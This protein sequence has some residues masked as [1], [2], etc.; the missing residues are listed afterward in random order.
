[1]CHPHLKPHRKDC[2]KPSKYNG[3]RIIL[4]G[5]HMK[6]FDWKIEKTYGKQEMTIVLLR[7]IIF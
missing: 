2:L 7:A 5:P 3:L 4:I 6:F 1:M